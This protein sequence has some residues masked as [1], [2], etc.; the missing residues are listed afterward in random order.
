VRPIGR[1]RLLGSV[2]GR[3]VCWRALE[4]ECRSLFVDLQ[5]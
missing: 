3:R 4:A 2:D 1:F 5:S